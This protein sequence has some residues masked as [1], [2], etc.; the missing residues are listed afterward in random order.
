MCRACGGPCHH[1]TEEYQ[2]DPEQGGQPGEE[3]RWPQQPQVGGQQQGGYQPTR[4][5]PPLD[6]RHPQGEYQSLNLSHL[7]TRTFK[8]ICG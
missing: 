4:Y 8:L 1:D 2:Y 5:Q 3:Q 7:T 6:P